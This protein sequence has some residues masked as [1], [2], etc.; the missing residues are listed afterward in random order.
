MG[1]RHITIVI[2]EQGNKKVSQYGQWDGYPEGQGYNILETL[3]DESIVSKLKENLNKCRF[4][5]VEGKDK[6]FI[7]SYNANAPTWSNE[8]DKRTDE[9]KRWFG[10]YIHRDVGSDILRNIAE[11][12]DEEILIGEHESLKWIDYWYEINFQTKKLKVCDTIEFDLKNLPKP[13]KFKKQIYKALEEE[14]E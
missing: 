4:I 1:T 6:K 13:K 7:E 2:D 5:D 3:K 9:Q 12:K 11:S 8:P 14:E 10:T